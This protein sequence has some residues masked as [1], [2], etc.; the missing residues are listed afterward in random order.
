MK[1]AALNYQDE[2]IFIKP[3]EKSDFH[4][5]ALAGSFKE[6][7]RNWP[8]LVDGTYENVIKYLEWAYEQNENGKWIVHALLTPNGEYIGQ[9]CYM[10]LRFEHLSVEI[11]GTW[12]APKFWG[13]K[14]NPA[15]KY[16]LLKHA[17]DNGARRV[18]L[19]T[20]ANNQK[21]RAAILKMGAKFEGI[22]RNHMLRPDGSMRDTPYFSITDYDWP[23][24]E[25]KL[26]ARINA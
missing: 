13:T 23:E 19:K 9:S 2:N 3:I 16:A 7:W 21:S 18:E 6:I 12:Y 14:I 15:A 24:V 4:G 5:L 1:L 17:F 26:L 8:F 10:A 20:D 22:F 25:N 11:G